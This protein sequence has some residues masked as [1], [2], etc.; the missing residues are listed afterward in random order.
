MRLVFRS[1]SGRQGLTGSG[2][3]QQ[4]DKRAQSLICAVSLML[5]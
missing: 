1:V 3:R 2:T 5:I 4:T